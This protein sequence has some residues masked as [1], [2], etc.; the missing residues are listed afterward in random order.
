MKQLHDTTMCSLC[1][2]SLNWWRAQACSHC[3]RAI[4]KHHAHMVRRPYSKVLYVV[5]ADC[6]QHIAASAF[7]S[8]ASRPQMVST[9]L[10]R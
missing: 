4:C 10:H 9:H 5:C 6:S 3:G 1:D 8:V 7:S 2:S